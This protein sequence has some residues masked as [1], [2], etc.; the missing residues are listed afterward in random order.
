[1]E[2]SHYRLEAL[3]QDGEFTLYRGLCQTNSKTIPQSILALSPILE[4]P[5]PA[6]L[7]KM[8]H[9][10]SLKDE[11]DPAWAIRPIALTQDESRAMLLFEDA[12]GEPLDRLLGRPFE[13]KQFLR[14]GIGLAAAL[15]QTH[16]RGLIHKDIKPS[17]VFVNAA[18]D[19]AWLTGFGIAS[20]LP[21]ER[22]AA[23]PPE[24]ISGTLAYM[25]PEQTGRMNRSIDSRSD[26][27]A[28]GITFYEL[29]TG[30]LPFTATD[31]ME[32]VHCHIA[33]QP[34][35][36]AEQLS[37]IPRSVSAIIMKL[38]AKTPEER[39]QTAA[40]LESDLR[41]CL[42][43]WDRERDI[44]DFPLGERDRPDRI[45]IPEKLYGR[46]GEIEWLLASFDR[47]VKSGTP[48][49]VLVSGHSGVGKSS[50]V[51]ELHRVLV[52][53]RGLFASGKF[54]QYKRDIPYS[55]LG[56]ALQSLTRRLLAKRDSDLA[57][58]SDA[59]REAL[60]PNGRLMVDLVPELKLIIGE[61]PA[62]PELPPQD[63]QRRF[64]LVFRQF[65]GVFAR[66]EH[67]L[68]LFLDDLQWLDSATLEVLEDL[69]TQAD[70][71]HLLMIGAYRDNEVDAAHPLARKLE[72]I[73]KAGARIKEIQLAP[74]SQQNVAQ[75]LMD[76][77]QCE[78]ERVPPLAQ[79]IYHKTRG[80]P[81]FSV[82]FIS[83]LEHETLLAFDHARG[84]WS[85]DLDRIH[86]KG[87]TDNVV[88]L[89]I[90]K[91]R[92]LPAETQNALQQ[93]ACLG[94]T[95]RSTT[96][97][98]VYGT[99]E[100]QVHSD[101]FEALRAEVVEWL[102]G[103]YKFIHDRVQEAV[104]SLIP[105]R[106]RAE[107]H[108]RSGRL[109]LAH[110]PPA[111]REKAIFEIVNQLNRGAALIVSREE[112]EELAGLN[113][114]AGQRAKSSAAHAV[115]LTYLVAGAEL[116]PEDGWDRRHDLR[117]A[118]E[119]NR[120]EC[121]YVTAQP[122]LAEER[123]TV[124]ARRAATLV[125]RAAVAA[126]RVDLYTTLDQFDRAIT[127]GLEY[128][129]HLGVNWSAHPSDEEVRREYEEIWSQLGTRAIEDLIELPILRDPV[130]L[131][132]LDILTKVALPA[133]VLDR[134]VHALVNC[135]AVSL[136]LELGNCDASCHAYVSV[137]V[138]AGARFGDYQAGYRFGRLGCELVEQRGW[139]RFQPRTYAV[140]A[141][142]VMPWTR[143][144][145]SSRDL[146]C[147]TIEDAN[148]IGD[149]VFAVGSCTSL[150]ANMLA[151]G[152]HLVDVEREAER[153]F[154]LARKARFGLMIDHMANQLGLVRMLRGFTRQFGRF[155]DEQ[156]EELAAE[157]RFASN[158]NLGTAECFYWIRKL[159][160]RFLAG[161]VAAAL[162]ASQ[163]AKRLLRTSESMLEEATYHFYSAL[164]RAAYCDS[165]S[166]DE[167]RQH[168]EILADHHRQFEI[169]AK[170]S[171]E[172]FENRAALVGAEIARIEG[173]V[174]EAEQLYEQAICSAHSNGIVNHEAIA[175]EV[176][177]RFYA[178]RGFQRFANAY[179]LEARYCYQRWGANGKVRQLDEIY[180]HLSSQEP[181]LDSRPSIDTSIEHLDLTMVVEVS[182]AVSGEIVLGKLI[183]TLLRTALE[184]AGAERALLVLPQGTELRVQAEAVTAG[185]SVTINLCDA[186]I[187][188]DQLPETVL[189]YTVRSQES[190]ILEDASAR[191]NFSDDEYIRGKRARSILC[192][193]LVRQGRLIAILYLEN[194]LAANVFSA[195]RITVLNVL[196]S[197]A[198]ISLENSRLYRGLQEREA[199]IRRLVDA[200][201]VGIL[202][203]E[204]DGRLLEANDAFLRIVGYDRED[205][206][207]GRIRW[208]DLT[209]PEWLELDFRQHLPELRAIG[210]VQPF[211]K[212]LFRKDGSR[213]PVLIGATRFEETGNQGVAFV[214]DL[215]ERKRAEEA[216]DKLH[217]LEADLAHL[218]RVSMLGELAA[219][220]A[221]EL[222]Q[223]IAAVAVNADACALCL[224]RDPPDLERAA[225]AA[226][227]V[228]AA[229]QHGGEIIDRVH[230]LY[231]RETP[232]REPV[233]LNEI[234]GEM[235]AMLGAK[236]MK[237]SVSI[238][239]ELDP[240][241]PRAVA[242][243]VQIQQVL[244][245][246]LLNGIE[247]MQETG[248]GKLTVASTQ[249]EDHQLLVTVSDS[250]VGISADQA[251]RLFEAFFTTKPEGTG[252]GL[253]ISQRIIESH[254]GLLW[255][256][257][258]P[259]RGTT[260][261]FALPTAEQQQD[262]AR[263]GSDARAA[264]RSG[265]DN[266]QSP[267]GPSPA[268]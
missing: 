58:W 253:S 121:E 116:L 190:V 34:R 109:L 84:R 259:G 148:R 21:R 139:K 73:R 145:K 112:R 82:Q 119:L 131:A 266:R 240:A 46:E 16:R 172:N 166:P 60:G 170:N 256:N 118:L 71:H 186:P 158:P 77:L 64:Q 163:Q 29:L 99:G 135:R 97:S 85:W 232:E 245:N 224:R 56:Q 23:E 225:N 193:P 30:S 171:P 144:F 187:T 88:D 61:Q 107:A 248:G 191:G 127:V 189:Q 25:A 178:A 128:L 219:A 261:G 198:A 20:R 38:L 132:T 203:A 8:E 212:E 262:S 22:Q 81:F 33:R 136:S 194:N 267:F 236:A 70:V 57:T 258:N 4:R 15:G 265:A 177:A 113:L 79:L 222:K 110:T 143:P 74:L 153:G 233:D 122:V 105:E 175:Y 28:L 239:T 151:A 1:M 6:T 216:R 264:H 130:S 182:Q 51:K 63:A 160:A 242:D 250:G 7:K 249:T 211:E 49:L 120:A 53:R 205:L 43:D 173:R 152:D 44:H 183:D 214:L 226:E 117:F 27:Y 55:T 129:R 213:V 37:D 237:Y 156:F 241:L 165:V 247:A 168:L 114:I 155:D 41:R 24:F 228:I 104:Y 169:W 78:P 123:L 138:I 65:I 234:V 196:A 154:E 106:L 140:F 227:T 146:L 100:A 95:A 94:N 147:R 199:K 230:S 181:A 201:I 76:A 229:A 96:L 180:P 192:L 69:L 161:D 206:A 5:A 68:A 202:I 150:C 124:L 90:G 2:L 254:G 47:V 3:H 40:G 32:W 39:Y 98:L 251:E 159:Q 257:P 86:A 149:V 260:F 179:L 238:H 188:S 18:V 45:L 208:I 66:P 263:D 87:F 204:L 235:I 101:L 91:L 244:M 102:E 184:H 223:P 75:L 126:L 252:M 141:A 174:L 167:R 221:H 103:S 12:G 164:A 108:L 268:S 157:R 207:S 50:V 54:D 209:P 200:N 255:A 134:N 14:C 243:R 231:R 11:L 93:L 13:L 52:P 9:E 111:K 10:F 89:M 195:R 67:P 210:S 220:L 246:L 125:E 83:A 17:N 35:A 80:N 115:A 92:R 218:N 133:L 26:L 62:V 197:S 36:P 19:Q 142:L 59:I 217:Q 31:P 137:A 72:G 185:G 48:E 176:A 42:V 162:H 215:S